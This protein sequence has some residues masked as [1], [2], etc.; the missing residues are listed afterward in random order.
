[1]TL[2]HKMNEIPVGV[3]VSHEYVSVSMMRHLTLLVSYGVKLW[4]DADFCPVFGGEEWR[5]P[6]LQYLSSMMIGPRT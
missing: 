4:G 2:H 3:F 5:C 6:A 1:M